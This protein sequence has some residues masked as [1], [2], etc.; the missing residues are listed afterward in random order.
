MTELTLS[1]CEP[2]TLLSHMA[3]Y[4]L[5]AILEAQGAPQVRVRWTE[6]KTRPRPEVSVPELDHSELAGLLL[7]H[8]KAMN[9]Q[10]SWVQQSLVLKTANSESARGLMSP[11]LA[12]LTD[13]PQWAHLQ[14]L[15][16]D[17]LESLT[18]GNQWLDLR[19]VS[20]LGE[21]SY[22]RRTRKETPLQDDAASRYEMQPRNQGAEFVGSRLR[23][24]AES[25]AARDPS[26]I[27]AGLR[28]ESLI[29]E[30]GSDKPDSRTATG[31]AGPGPT[32]N[33]LAWCALWGISQL[34]TVM[35]V[36]RPADTAG[37]L[38]FR[39]Y[40]WF[41]APVWHAPWRPAR[42][43]SILASRSLRVLASLGIQET[44]LDKE[45]SQ[46]KELKPFADTAIPEAR[47]W[48][49]ARDVAGVIRF[50]IHRFGSTNAPERRAMRGEPISTDQTP[51]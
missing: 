43:R 48:L 47:S 13:R 9:V 16:H 35:L 42:L 28:G 23:K 26:E 38:S 34:P 36:T 33:A 41:Y 39:R 44:V 37:H 14:R 4:G 17:V 50:P 7:Q 25:V 51:A 46:R 2:R 31:L 12:T 1:G 45:T 5:A 8:A 30:I 15:R 40:E 3:L 29:D 27:L 21:P 11:R 6:D 22:W 19:F 20:A 10:D 24:L 49:R 18:T 32:D